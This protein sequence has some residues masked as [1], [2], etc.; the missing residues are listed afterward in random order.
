MCFSEPRSVCVFVEQVQQVEFKWSLW[1]Q[2]IARGNDRYTILKKY[3]QHAAV[4]MDME[5]LQKFVRD[6]D[7]EVETN[8]PG[9][10]H[11][12]AALAET[13]KMLRER[14]EVL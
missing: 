11:G 4:K 1:V 12:V 7:T 8:N 2:I 14:F 9:L 3:Y 6:D 10:A 5:T 13:D